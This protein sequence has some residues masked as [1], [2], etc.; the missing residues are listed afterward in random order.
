MILVLGRGFRLA[1]V[2]G[3][4]VA[5]LVELGLR[6]ISLNFTGE[7][8]TSDAVT[9]ESTNVSLASTSASAPIAIII[10]SEFGVL[11]SF[12]ICCCSRHI[13]GIEPEVLV[14][15]DAVGSVDE[16]SSA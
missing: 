13:K 4:F 5:L 14:G 12:L 8:I 9:A 3:A 11:T 16:I 7:S 1:A 6:P 10:T 2:S 15:V